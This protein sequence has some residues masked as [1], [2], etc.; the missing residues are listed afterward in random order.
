MSDRKVERY[1][2]YLETESGKIIWG[3]VHA[4]G[5]MEA[6]ENAKALTE[7]NG[8]YNRNQLKNKAVV[9]L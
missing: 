4:P 7:K 8:T 2:V 6:F 1:E 5:F 9:K 3:K